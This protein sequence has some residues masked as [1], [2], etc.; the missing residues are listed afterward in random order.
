MAQICHLLEYLH[1]NDIGYFLDFED[2]YITI[3][4]TVKIKN[5]TSAYS[6]TC[7]DETKSNKGMDDKLIMPNIED[8]RIV[9]GY[10]GD[11]PGIKD[12]NK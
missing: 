3:Q 5:F 1:K 9:A 11:E 8:Y 7:W 12:K 4:G 2:I 10:R 6:V